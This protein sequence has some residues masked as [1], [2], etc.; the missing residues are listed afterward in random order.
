MITKLIMAVLLALA[1]SACA[2]MKATPET[3][4]QRQQYLDCKREASKISG[5]DYIDKVMNRNDYMK[6]CM[7]SY[8]EG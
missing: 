7:A 5:Y 1:L 3:A 8:Q 6:A 2:G 4:Q